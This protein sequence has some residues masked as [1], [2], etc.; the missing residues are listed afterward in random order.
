MKASAGTPAG[1]EREGLAADAARDAPTAPTQFARKASGLIRSASLLDVFGLNAMNALFVVGIAWF[2]LYMPLY[3]GGNPYI[4]VGFIVLECIGMTVMYLK[5][6]VIYPRSGGDYVWNSRALHPVFGFIGSL[7]TVVG[8]SFWIAMG[9]VYGIT[10]GITPLL[11]T[12]GIQLN[13]Q[14]MVD[15]G[16]WLQGQ[17][18][19]FI[20]SL[21]LLVAFLVLMLLGGN[22]AYFRFQ[23]V[24]IVLSLFTLVVCVIY[25]FTASRSGALANL[26]ELF[27]GMGAG[28]ATEL[29]K[30]VA[31]AF[32]WGQTFLLSFWAAYIMS[33][34]WSASIG[35]EVK[36]PGKTQV[37]GGVLALGWMAVWSVVVVAAMYTLLGA[38]FMLN[39][40]TA[41]ETSTF[42]PSTTPIYPTLI[43]GA[44]GNPWVTILMMLCFTVGI[45]AMIAV[46]IMLIA[47][48]IFAYSMDR[49]LPKWAC[50]V[51]ARTHAPTSA[52]LITFVIA[53]VFA[54]L[55]SYGYLTALGAQWF[56]MLPY[57]LTCVAAIWLPYRKKTRNLWE[58]SP[59]ARRI[60]GIPTL[61]LWGIAAAAG[62]SAVTYIIVADPTYGVSPFHQLGQFLIAPS[63]F[64]A[65]AV[66]YFVARAFQ[67]RRGVNTD[68]NFAEIPPE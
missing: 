32:S 68:L 33:A 10:Y 61:T 59:D 17:S 28:S 5:M 52:M 38:P 12:A 58:S 47:R 36:S 44:I 11:I 64:V 55:I 26:D 6:A 3:P 13:N 62:L 50:N 45:I 22:K 19:V 37:R 34:F 8:N 57:F 25:G 30:G 31:P 49:L 27:A 56:F 23:I 2:L 16:T 39:M 60:L 21:L 53:T 46:N 66:Y 9:G 20:V 7:G 63:F 35:G 54:F 42:G 43:A 18:Q 1:A 65:A 51:S 67:R 4:A 41:F 29:A 48:P 40:S 15:A 14:S 24:A